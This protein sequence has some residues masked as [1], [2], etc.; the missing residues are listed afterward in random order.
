MLIFRHIC[1]SVLWLH[2][3]RAEPALPLRGQVQ[4]GQG[5]GPGQPVNK[6]SANIA[7]FSVR[8]RKQKSHIS[9]VVDAVIE[10]RSL[11]VMKVTFNVKGL[12]LVFEIIYEGVLKI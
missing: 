5:Q 3:G 10:Q 12:T 6:I 7:I 1:C 8:I 11:Y 9:Q 2:C 4:A